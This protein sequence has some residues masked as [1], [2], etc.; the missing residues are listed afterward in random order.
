MF[1]QHQEASSGLC[2]YGI[3]APEIHFVSKCSILV[4]WY[5]PLIQTQSYGRRIRHRHDKILFDQFELF[6]P[7]DCPREIQLSKWELICFYHSLQVFQIVKYLAIMLT[8]NV[9]IEMLPSYDHSLLTFRIY[10]GFSCSSSLR[11]ESVYWL[12][13]VKLK[14]ERWRTSLK[15]LF[16]RIWIWVYI[17]YKLWL[18]LN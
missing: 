6:T 2:V 15:V 14:V 5:G 16:L 3:M 7:L 1:I 18:E 9:V 11:E 10:F 12:I 8:I 13:F 4:T 17:N